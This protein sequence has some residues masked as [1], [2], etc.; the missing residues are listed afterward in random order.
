[1]TAPQ[2]TNYYKEKIPSGYKAGRISNFSPEQ[3]EL[4]KTLFSHLGP[5][6]YLSKLASGDEA[7]F[8][9]VE[10]PAL[11]QFAGLQGQMASRFSGMGLG[12]ARNSSGFQNTAS[13]ASSDFAMNLQAQRQQLQQ[14]AIRD[15]MGMSNQLLGQRPMETTLTEK[16]TPW[17]QNA[18]IGFAGGLGQGVGKGMTGGF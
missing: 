9:Q 14:Q 17:W 12:G 1:M 15:L 7:T 18:A 2:N 3:Q 6:S 11:K 10:A 13:Q 16:Q 8:N 4:F 5:D